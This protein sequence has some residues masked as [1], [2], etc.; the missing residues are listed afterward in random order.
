MW[1]ECHP[2]WFATERALRRSR[3]PAFPPVPASSAIHPQLQP[4]S[5][6]ETPEGFEV[7]R[8]KPNDIAS[9]PPCGADMRETHG[10]S[11]PLK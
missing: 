6:S 9:L 2:D 4:L 3:K 1:W 11:K 10:T 7:P 8:S 5:Q